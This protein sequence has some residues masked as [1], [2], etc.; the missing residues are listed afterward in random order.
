M[1]SADN[2]SRIVTVA[3]GIA[4]GMTVLIVDDLVRTG[5]TL[6]ECGKALREHGAK[7]VSAFCAH[8]VFPGQSWKRFLMGGDR[9]F[10]DFFFI[11]NSIE[12]VTNEIMEQA[13]DDCFKVLE[14]EPLVLQDL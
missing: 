3:D 4:K 11:T 9:Q 5:G 1:R 10:F 13:P 12:G 8:G 6:A 14:I 7:S 2:Q